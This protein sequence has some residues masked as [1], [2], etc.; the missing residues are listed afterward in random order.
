[1]GFLPDPG[2][3]PASPAL[4]GGFFIMLIHRGSLKNRMLPV[5]CFYVQSKHVLEYTVVGFLVGHLGQEVWTG[6][7]QS[8]ETWGGPHVIL[9]LVLFEGSRFSHAIQDV[10]S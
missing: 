4:A 8:K 2:I 1:M 5:H 10:R 7:Y 6:A 3:E 9:G